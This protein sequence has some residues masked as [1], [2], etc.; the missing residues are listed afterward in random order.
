MG[1]FLKSIFYFL[2]GDVFVKGSINYEKRRL[3]HNGLCTKIYP[4]IIVVPE[5]TNDVSAIVKITNKHKVAI[6]IRSGGHSYTCQ[7][8]KQGNNFI[9]FIHGK[10]FFTDQFY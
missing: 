10:I 8:T 3:I 4:D 2:Q 9:K 7:S 1:W 6:S 5:S